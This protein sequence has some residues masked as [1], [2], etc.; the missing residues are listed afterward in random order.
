M[1]T[2]IWF[3]CKNKLV[4]IF[5]SLQIE[6]VELKNLVTNYMLA[7]QTYVSND[8]NFPAKRCYQNYKNFIS[9]DTFSLQKNL[10]SLATISIPCKN[11]LATIQVLYKKMLVTFSIS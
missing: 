6:G 1:S 8:L 4:T 3:P 9:K 10:T 11:M 7:F 5:I 2:T